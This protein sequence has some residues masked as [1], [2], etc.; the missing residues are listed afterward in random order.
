VKPSGEIEKKACP[1]GM[2]EVT[3]QKMPGGSAGTDRSK[4]GV[5]CQSDWVIIETK[6]GGQCAEVGTKGMNHEG[7]GALQGD[8]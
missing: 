3:R 4:E 5:L 1:E 7:G 6:E 2:V 8:S